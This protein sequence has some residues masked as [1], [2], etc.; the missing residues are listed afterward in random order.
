[1][2]WQVTKYATS[3]VSIALGMEPVVISCHRYRWKWLAELMA[4]LVPP[5]GFFIFW[6]DV[7]LK[8]E[9]I[10]GGKQS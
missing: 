1:M 10:K 2:A 5:S 8:L 4:L 3:S 6:A 9:V 7:K